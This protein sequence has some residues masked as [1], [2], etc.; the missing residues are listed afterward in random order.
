MKFL[1]LL[2]LLPLLA[3]AA[4][5]PAAPAQANPETASVRP[6]VERAAAGLSAGGFVLAE[7]DGDHVTYAAAGHPSPREGLPPEHLIFEI[8]SITKVFTS[9]LLAEAVNEGK[10]KLTDPIGK[11]LPP[12][13]TL[14]PGTAAITLEQLATHT[15]GLPALPTN[16]HPANQNDPYADYTVGQ[17]YDF[18]REYQPEQPAPQPASYS[19]VGV[20]LLGHLLER[21]YGQPYAELVAARITGPLGL[22]DTVIDLSPAQA[23]RLAPPH[24]GSFAMNLWRIPTLAGAG[25]LRSTAADLARFAQALL[26]PKDPALAAAWELARQPRAAYGAKGHIGLNIL[27]AE[28]NGVTVYNHSGGTGGSRSY[29]ELVPELHR[30]TVLLLNNDTVEPARLVALVRRPPSPAGSGPAGRAEEP[31]AAKQLTEY[32]GVYAI[33]ARGRFTFLIDNTGRLRGRLIGQAFLPAFYAGHD[34]FFLRVVEAE[35]QFERD[36]AGRVTAVVLHQNGREVRAARTE[37]PVPTVRFL[38]TDEARDYE[39]RYGEHPPLQFEVKARGEQV[40]AKLLGQ[41]AYPVF[42]DRPDHFA[43]DIVPA[44]LTFERNAQGEI[45][46]LVLHQNGRDQRAVRLPDTPAKP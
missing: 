30:A 16:F 14:K 41:A 1:V 25:A 9:L 18:L 6:A 20:G 11:F 45:T 37:E 33:D 35:Y 36:A 2:V 40:F 21:I 28:R 4:T 17:L 43:Y 10:A 27:I 32:V 13:V 42:C 7:V 8:G 12:D 38:T 5:E 3:G 34:R 22:K 46:A 26:Q 19:N 39:G 44:A 15:S 23:D 24:S 29:L 31:I